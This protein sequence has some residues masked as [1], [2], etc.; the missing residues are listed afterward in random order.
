[1]TSSAI[2]R[3]GLVVALMVCLAGPVKAQKAHPLDLPLEESQ[4]W[5]SIPLKDALEHLAGS[6]GESFAL[7]GLEQELDAGKGPTVTFQAKSGMT[8]G[9]C[10]RTILA[11]LP[12]YEIEVVSDHLIDL[13][14]VGA[15]RDPDNILNLRVPSFDVVSMGAYWILAA[16]RDLIPVLNEALTPKPEPGK[17]MITLYM[18]GYQGGPPITLHLKNVTVR[19]ILN[20]A[21]EATEPFYTRGQV[22]L[23]PEG[24][25]YTF[26]PNPHPGYV[27][28]SWATLFGLPRTF[29]LQNRNKEKPPSP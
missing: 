27:K 3:A 7:F 1:M 8:L 4:P 9:D 28:H 2:Y 29:R 25:V 20:A 22:G 12:P 16:P 13:R 23:A 14:P 18:G 26:D 10:L 24:W 15:K 5:D 21:S 6:V 17:Q 19:E 11:Q